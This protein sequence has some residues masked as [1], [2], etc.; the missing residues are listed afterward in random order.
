MKEAINFVLAIIFSGAFLFG[1]GMTI[2]GIHDL[3]KN[4]ALKKVSK[5]LSSSE[6][7]ANALTNERLDY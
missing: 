5:G 7:F 2:K 3:I 1:G 6:K 4:E